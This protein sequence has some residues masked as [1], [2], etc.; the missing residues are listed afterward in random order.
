MIPKYIL[1]T[2][3]VDIARLKKYSRFYMCNHSLA[4]FG[5]EI[6]APIRMTF[7]KDVILV[8]RIRD[9]KVENVATDNRDS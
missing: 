9:E 2:M 5:F 3:Y 4:K 7:R 1:V 8:E 6:D